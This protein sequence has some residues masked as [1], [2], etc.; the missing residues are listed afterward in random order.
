MS[1]SKHNTIN[2]FDPGNFLGSFFHLAKDVIFFSRSFYKGMRSEGGMRNPCIFLA[3][4]ALVHT[5]F[6]GLTLKKGAIIALSLFNGLVMPFVTA[7]ILYVIV[8]GLFKGSGTYEAAFRVT[9]YSAATALF[10]WVPMGG[11][12]L[13]I[14]RLYLIA[15]GLSYTFSLRL[16]KTLLAVCITVA[17]YV[18]VFSSLNIMSG[19][20]GPDIMP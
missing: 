10:S 14:Y 16:S 20:P 13:E 8:T 1:S 19:T 2:D 11:F 15:L 9:A 6:V 4:C 3:G 12:I 17:I 7:W 18:F 5:L